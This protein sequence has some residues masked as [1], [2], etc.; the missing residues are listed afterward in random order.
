MCFI[1]K[2]ILFSITKLSLSWHLINEVNSSVSNGQNHSREKILTL[3]TSDTWELH[4]SEA[5]Y[6]RSNKNNNHALESNFPFWKADTLRLH[7]FH[8]G[9]K[10]VFKCFKMKV[11][12]SSAMGFVKISVHWWSVSMNFKD[13]IPFLTK[14]YKMNLNLNMF[15]PRMQNW[16]LRQTNCT[17]IIT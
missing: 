2:A 11:S 10:T 8:Y 9:H 15:S 4:L 16:I 12:L 13:K 7:P 5:S 3:D 14:S 17:S 6:P 1:K